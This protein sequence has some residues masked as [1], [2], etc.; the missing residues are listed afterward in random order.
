MDGLLGTFCVMVKCV[1]VFGIQGRLRQ[2]Q[3][4]KPTACDVRTNSWATLGNGK[5]A[6][7]HP[8][9]LPATPV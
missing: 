6:H 4:F 8:S 5:P 1:L 2:R 9:P 3:R 7:C